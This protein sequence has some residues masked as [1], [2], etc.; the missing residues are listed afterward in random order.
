LESHLTEITV[1]I[2]VAG[3]TQLRASAQATFERHCRR[4]EELAR[5]L[6]E[7]RA[8]AARQARLQAIRADHERQRDLLRMAEGHH[9]AEQ[10]RS[11]V[12]AVMR[13]RGGEPAEADQVAA[14][15]SWARA[16]A[17]RTDPIMRLIFDE[18]GRVSLADAALPEQDQ[19]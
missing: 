3:E 14:W 16:V 12:D 2:I 17:D 8:E 7:Q 13:L 19:D 18:G 5:H 4:R 1:E 6:V 10:I 9:R 11:L 15:A